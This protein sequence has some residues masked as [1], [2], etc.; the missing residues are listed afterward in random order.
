MT[1]RIKKEFEHEAVEKAIAP[2]HLVEE[3]VEDAWE[4][5]NEEQDV[6]F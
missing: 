6:D 5:Y 1:F 4:E 3:L 2:A